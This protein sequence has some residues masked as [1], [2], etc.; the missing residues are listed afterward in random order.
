MAERTGDLDSWAREMVRGLPP[1]APEDVAAMVV[2]RG[3]IPS[4]KPQD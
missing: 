2:Y 1:M 4:S 3:L